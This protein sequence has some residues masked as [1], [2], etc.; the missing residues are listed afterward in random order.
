MQCV[1]FFLISFEDR[2]VYDATLAPLGKTSAKLILACKSHVC[3]ML[4]GQPWHLC[5]L[6]IEVSIVTRE[7]ACEQ[8]AIYLY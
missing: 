1:F 8:S 5:R 7:L 4:H 3:K 2:E 6:K